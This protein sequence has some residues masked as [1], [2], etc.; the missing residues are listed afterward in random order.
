[1]SRFGS[2]FRIFGKPSSLRGQL[3]KFAQTRQKGQEV[4]CSFVACLGCFAAQLLVD[5]PKRKISENPIFTC[6][7]SE[8]ADNWKPK[9]DDVVYL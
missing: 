5:G 3:Q 1:M 2:L 4:A 9:R 7:K 6:A 8:I